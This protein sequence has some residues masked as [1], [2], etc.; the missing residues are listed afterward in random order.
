MKKFLLIILFFL[1]ANLFALE[2]FCRFE[3]VYKNSSTQQGFFL[4]K[5]DKLRYEYLDQ[6]LYTIIVKNKEYFLILNNHKDSF[7][8]LEE[9]TEMID[10][11]S[12]I[13]LDFPNIKNIYVRSDYTYIIEKNSNN[14]IKRVAIKSNDLNISINFFNCE[15]KAIED[16]YFM[17][18]PLRK[19]TL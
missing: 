4:L 15:T 11:I 1:P 2:V 19:Y 6:N 7:S 13:L 8:K 16:K 10:E 9:N 5:E 18:F 12:N 14:F 17:H 3:E